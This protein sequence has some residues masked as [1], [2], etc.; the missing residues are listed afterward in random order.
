MRSRYR[1]LFIALV[2]GSYLLLFAFQVLAVTFQ[3]PY[4]NPRYLQMTRIFAT[5]TA[6]MR[7]IE[8]TMTAARRQNDATNTARATTTQRPTDA[9][10]TPQTGEVSP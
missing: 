7:A 6:V 5:N 10:R 8:A 9:T 2:V 1:K 3:E 4:R